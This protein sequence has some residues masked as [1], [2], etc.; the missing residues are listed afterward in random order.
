MADK[1]PRLRGKPTERKAID[2]AARKTAG[3]GSVVTLLNVEER[4]AAQFETMEP[5]FSRIAQRQRA[6]PRS[7]SEA[8][9]R[10]IGVLD[11]PLH[12]AFVSRALNAVASLAGRLPAEAISEAVGESSDYAVLLRALSAP[13]TLA[14]LRESDPLA[15]A[16]LRGVQQRQAIL[17]AEG[18]TFT[19]EQVAQRLGITRQAVDKRRRQGHILALPIGQHRCAY[20]AWQFTESGMLP[21][22][23]N[24]LAELSLPDPWTQAAFF[25]SPNTYLS[26]QRPIDELRRGNL[27]GVR[28]AAWSM[29]EQG[30]P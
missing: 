1:T 19:V 3:R 6:V 25:L 23:D 28:R 7:V 22:F 11:D 5:V 24:V 29:G 10:T 12:A 30:G 26:D 21:G 14:V 13:A 9:A 27:D 20:P 16:R 8:M 15:E 2:V 17:A 18:G 4:V